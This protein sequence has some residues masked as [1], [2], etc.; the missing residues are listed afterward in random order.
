MK[1]LSFRKIQEL[2]HRK[3]TY[4]KAS[5]IYGDLTLYSPSSLAAETR[6]ADRGTLLR[7]NTEARRRRS[8]E[9]LLNNPS[10]QHSI[11]TRLSQ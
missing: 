7:I 5:S 3:V 10:T 1:V 2:T 8:S 9:L 4:Y 6:H 11:A